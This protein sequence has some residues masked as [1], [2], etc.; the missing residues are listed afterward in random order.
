MLSSETFR[1]RTR[2]I[3]KKEHTSKTNGE[4]VAKMKNNVK[5][6]AKK[7]EEERKA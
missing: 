2:L 5:S 1:K 6:N 4:P 3:A 7:I